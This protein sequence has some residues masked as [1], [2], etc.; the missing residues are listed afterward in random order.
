MN[1]QIVRYLQHSSK[2]FFE[3]REIVEIRFCFFLGVESR[4][5]LEMRDLEVEIRKGLGL[6]GSVAICLC[7]DRSC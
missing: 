2:K 7:G 3:S 6:R 4:E 1:L 5:P